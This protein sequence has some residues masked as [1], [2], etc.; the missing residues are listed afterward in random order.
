M[1]SLALTP[2]QQRR[3]AKLSQLAGR[4]PESLLRFVLRDGLEAT[5]QD[6]R[7]AAWKRSSHGSARRK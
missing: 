7:E 4:T 3:I 6:V 5:E 1:R 2:A